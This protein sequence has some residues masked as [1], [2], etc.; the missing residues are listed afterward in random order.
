[1]WI[2]DGA[3]RR[4]EWHDEEIQW[5]RTSDDGRRTLT[6]RRSPRRSPAR[7]AGTLTNSGKSVTC[8]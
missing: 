7:V 1:M 5:V 2:C 4:D 8:Q 6:S 3:C